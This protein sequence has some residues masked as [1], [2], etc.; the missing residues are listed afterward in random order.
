MTYNLV[1]LSRTALKF[2]AKQNYNSISKIENLSNASEIYALKSGI[3][4]ASYFGY[5]K[6]FYKPTAYFYP[7]AYYAGLDLATTESNS[8]LAHAAKNKVLST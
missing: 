6:S 1:S 8:V 7:K 5:L 2:Y 4:S 3:E